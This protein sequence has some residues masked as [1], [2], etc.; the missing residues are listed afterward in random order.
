MWQIRTDSHLILQLTLLFTY[1]NNLSYQQFHG[2]IIG[3]LLGTL[4]LYSLPLTWW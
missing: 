3:L 4:G 1:H 2:I